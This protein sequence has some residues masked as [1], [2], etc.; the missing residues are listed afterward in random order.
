MA[1]RQPLLFPSLSSTLTHSVSKLTS[2]WQRAIL[3]KYPLFVPSDPTLPSLM[4]TEEHQA[5]ESPVYC[6][7]R[8]HTIPWA[9][10][11][12]YILETNTSNP[13]KKHPRNRR[14]AY[15]STVF[16]DCFPDL[17][18]RR[19]G[20]NDG[21]ATSGAGLK[22]IGRLARGRRRASSIRF[23]ENSSVSVMLVHAEGEISNPIA[24][25]PGSPQRA[26]RGELRDNVERS[27]TTACLWCSSRE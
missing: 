6:Q 27:L 3:V 7:I 4:L 15:F 19:K 14:A 11:R 13:N 24:S 26:V 12:G 21:A 1:I 18:T 20:A 17:T 2:R 10:P 23:L 16:D 9:N 8:N 22:T 25:P 5:F